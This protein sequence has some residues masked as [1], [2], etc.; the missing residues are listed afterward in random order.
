MDSSLFKRPTAFSTLSPRP[1]FPPSFPP[2]SFPSFLPSI[3]QSFQGRHR[4]SFSRSPPFP[5][6]PFNAEQ[7]KAAAKAA[8][9]AKAPRLFCSFADCSG[10]LP[11]LLMFSSEEREGGREASLSVG[12]R[13]GLIGVYHELLPLA[14]RERE[15]ERLCII[16]NVARALGYIGPWECL[17]AWREGGRERAGTPLCFCTCSAGDR[18][19]GLREAAGTAG[20]SRKRDRDTND[21]NKNPVELNHCCA[22]VRYTMHLLETRAKIT[23]MPSSYLLLPSPSF[24]LPS[25][26]SRLNK[27]AIKFGRSCRESCRSSFAL[28]PPSSTDC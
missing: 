5:L 7:R 2:S 17:P 10:S 12:R 22:H 28:G 8:K 9:A 27:H 14:P 24:P 16:S 13:F 23:A 11:P 20:R 25:S 1:S 18:R 26:V 4:R 15:G 6:S 19:R 3:P 21:E